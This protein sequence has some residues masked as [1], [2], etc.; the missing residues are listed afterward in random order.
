MSD[1]DKLLVMRAFGMDKRA[2][3]MLGI[4]PASDSPKSGTMTKTGPMSGATALSSLH[5]Y[6]RGKTPQSSVN[7]QNAKKPEEEQ[8]E[9]PKKVEKLESASDTPPKKAPPKKPEEPSENEVEYKEAVLRKMA[10]GGLPIGPGTLV[11]ALHGLVREKDPGEDRAQAMGRSALTGVGT[12]VGMGLGAFGGGL[13]GALL[14]KKLFPEKGMFDNA[15]KNRQALAALLGMLLGTAGGGYAGYRLSRRTPKG[16]EKKSSALGPF[17]KVAAE[18]MDFDLPTERKGMSTTAKVLLGALAG[19]GIPVALWHGSS[20]VIRKIVKKI[21]DYA[22]L[23]KLHKL[24]SRHPKATKALMY[25]P[26]AA[27]GILGGMSGGDEDE[28]KL[29]SFHQ[30]LVKASEGGLTAGNVGAMTADESPKDLIP[31]LGPLGGKVLGGLGGITSGLGMSGIGGK[32]QEWSQN[33][34]ARSIAGGGTA[35]LGA[36]LTALAARRLMRGRQDEAED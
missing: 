12:D 14:G 3:D 23:E 20:P 6:T 22:P 21:Y 35:A 24:P 9:T 32:L 29:S 25:A 17:H 16:K 36:L 13:G 7:E 19:A 8:E 18:D 1:N 31:L 27:G 28:F 4:G 15:S 30:T 26:A 11:G 2:A 10:L 5:S 34:T 33:P